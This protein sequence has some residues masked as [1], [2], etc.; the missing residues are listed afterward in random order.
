VRL[1]TWDIE[2]GRVALHARLTV[3]PGLA[4]DERALLAGGLATLAGAAPAEL[5][6]RAGDLPGA[7]VPPGVPAVDEL[8]VQARRRRDHRSTLATASDAADAG[9]RD[10]QDTVADAKVRLT[11]L[12]SRID[13]AAAAVA[14]TAAVTARFRAHR[15]E[16][17]SEPVPLRRPSDAELA[18]A[19]GRVDEWRIRAELVAGF[20]A[21]APA[22]LVDELEAAHAAVADAEGGGLLGRRKRPQLR[23]REAAAAAAIGVPSYEAWLVRSSGILPARDDAR[24]LAAQRELAEAEAAL[25]ALMTRVDEGAMSER[26]AELAGR[27]ASVAQAEIRASGAAAALAAVN[28]EREA[29]ELALL[30]AERDLADALADRGAIAMI[31]A[32]RSPTAGSGDVP[33]VDLTGVDPAELELSLLSLLVARESVGQPL[34]VDDAF[35]G[36]DS[37]RRDAALDVLAWASEAVQVVYLEAGRSIAARVAAL[38]PDRASVVDLHPA[39]TPSG[40]S[41]P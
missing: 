37:T 29:A 24:V 21:E 41:A 8:V 32:T 6:L 14:E 2:G 36:L 25:A 5:V 9:V 13:Q 39:A 23:A 12:A 31:R 40:P 11:A 19:S 16:L 28:A 15:D 17:A 27:Q 35:A 26:K 22:A 30:A 3:I 7:I 20:R 34:V 10:A 33:A 18:A 38:G 4:D 1:Q